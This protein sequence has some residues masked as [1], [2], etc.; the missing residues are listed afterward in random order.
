MRFCYLVYYFRKVNWKAKTM[1]WL[2]LDLSLKPC[3]VME[4]L[5]DQIMKWSQRRYSTRIVW[6]AFEVHLH[7]RCCTWSVC[8]GP[9]EGSW[10]LSNRWFETQMR[11]KLGW[12]S[13]SGKLYWAIGTRRHIQ[14]KSFGSKRN[15]LHQQKKKL[16]K[17]KWNNCLVLWS[18][19]IWQ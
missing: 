14:C 10:L 12:E 19:Q 6:T 4:W 17:T 15:L 8:I 2:Q 18:T 13:F 11:E 1:F 9:V 3:L 5:R 7:W 16:M